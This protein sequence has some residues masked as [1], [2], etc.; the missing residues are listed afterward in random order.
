MTKSPFPGMDPYLERHWGDVHHSLVI[1][2]RNQ[3]RPHLPPHLR[4]QAEERVFVESD[5]IPIQDRRPDV[6]VVESPRS[7][8]SVAS[9]TTLAA[10]W[11]AETEPFTVRIRASPVTE[12]FLQIIDAQSGNRVVTVIEFISPTNKPPGPGR[13]EYLRKREECRQAAV[14]LVEID[15]TLD[16]SRAG[17]F[18]RSG[19]PDR[20]RNA[21][22]LAS[23]S[24]ATKPDELFVYPIPLQY[25]LP[26]IAVPLRA[27]DVDVSLDL[28]PLIEQAYEGYDFLD[29]S[30]PPSVALSEADEKWAD[31]LL[32][33]SGKRG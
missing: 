20:S 1:Y 14:N 3:L 11:A 4:V 6:F 7:A 18:P 19:M 13:D 16:G 12:I 33:A 25:S 29:Y 10:P 24:R 17:L 32:R 28:Q 8:G 5:D 31:S 30:Q 27:D 22:Y 15:L 2:A 21:A 23:V 26:S 9:T